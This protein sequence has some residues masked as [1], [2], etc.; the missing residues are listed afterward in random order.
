ME[1]E[2][3]DG[4]N[5]KEKEKKR[6]NGIKMENVALTSRDQYCDARDARDA[7]SLF[8]QLNSI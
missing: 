8:H 2:A 4:I 6:K 5:K 7:S 1:E 3:E